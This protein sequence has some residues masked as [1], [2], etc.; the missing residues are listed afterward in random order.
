MQKQ[1][2]FA[3]Q[4]KNS[5][6]NIIARD[7]ISNS[8]PGLDDELVLPVAINRLSNLEDSQNNQ[9]FGHDLTLTVLDD[10]KTCSWQYDSKVLNSESVSS[11]VESTYD[12]IAEHS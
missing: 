7:K 1:I 9:T 4:H 10:G 12:S 3:K 6:L 11:N 8:L 5:V 2:E